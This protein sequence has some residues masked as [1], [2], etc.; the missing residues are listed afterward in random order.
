MLHHWLDWSWKQLVA[1]FQTRLKLKTT[2]SFIFG[3][4]KLESTRSFILDSFEPGN[5][6]LLHYWLDLIWKQ[7]VASFETRLKLKTT[8]SLIFGCLKLESTCTFILDSLEPG[9]NLSLH[10]WQDW[11]WKQLV[12]SFQTRLK[13]KTT[14]SFIFG[15]LKIRIN[16]LFH[17][18]IV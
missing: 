11:S 9:N 4:L 3:C 7:L 18:W 14:C 16:F 12:A 10:Y 6:L 1:S 17:S 13:L 2:C 15:C 8:C 5:K